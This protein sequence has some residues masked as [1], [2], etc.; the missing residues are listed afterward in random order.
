[1]PLRNAPAALLMTNSKS[2]DKLPEAQREVIADQLLLE[3]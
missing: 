2:A 3:P 1:M